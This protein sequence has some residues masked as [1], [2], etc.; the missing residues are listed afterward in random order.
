MQ[1]VLF[2]LLGLG[3][4]ALIAGGIIAFFALRNAP[5]GYEDED[6]FVGVTKGDEVLLKQ[7]NQEHRYTPAHGSMDLAV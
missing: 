4:F 1:S 5:E 7:F 2:Y 3:A 6:G